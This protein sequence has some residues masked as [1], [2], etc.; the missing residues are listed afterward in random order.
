MTDQ[1]PKP[2]YDA[3]GHRLFPHNHYSIDDGSLLDT[4]YVGMLEASGWTPDA[5]TEMQPT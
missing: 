4:P 5:P 3:E 2:G 1:L